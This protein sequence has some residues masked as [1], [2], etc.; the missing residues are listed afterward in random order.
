VRSISDA[1]GT[2]LRSLGLRRGVER[3]RAVAAWP[4]AAAS[5]VGVDA[6]RSRAVRIE[7]ETLVVAVSSPVLAQ[8]LRLRQQEVLEALARLA[9][10]AHVRALRFVPR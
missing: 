7:G 3:A 10:E 5:V 1:L 6:S 4:A 2:T 9:P 8:E